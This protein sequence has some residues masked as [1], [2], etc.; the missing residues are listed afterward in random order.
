MVV[1]AIRSRPISQWLK[2]N[3]EFKAIA[4]IVK[5]T[6]GQWEPDSIFQVDG[7]TVFATQ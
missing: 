5:L 7:K 4:Y 3:R 2:G 6:P 1:D